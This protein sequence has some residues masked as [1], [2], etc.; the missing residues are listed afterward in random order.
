MPL[1]KQHKKQPM[2]MQGEKQQ[3]EE[4]TWPWEAEFLMVSEVP[5]GGRSWHHTLPLPLGVNT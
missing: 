1:E 2:E 5:E 4:H 3:I